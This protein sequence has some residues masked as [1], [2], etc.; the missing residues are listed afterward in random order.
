ME[1]LTQLQKKFAEEYVKCGNA[2]EAYNKAGYKGKGPTASVNAHRLLN[3]AK[4]MSYIDLLNGEVKTDNIADARE[5]QEYWTK[6]MRGETTEEVV[7]ANGE[8]VTVQVSGA[9]RLR[10]SY[11]LGK[12]LGL[13][14]ER[15]EV[16]LTEPVVI[17]KGSPKK[18]DPEVEANEGE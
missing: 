15:Q 16:T 6:V 5:I 18:Y 3:N 13:F 1:K 12:S 7:A 4:V 8:V 10:A 9:N 17:V 14:I 2:T 11:H